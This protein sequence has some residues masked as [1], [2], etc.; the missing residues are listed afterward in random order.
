MGQGA[1]TPEH[2]RSLGSHTVPH[3]FPSQ[4]ALP[5]ATCGHGV[6]LLPHVSSEE[7]GTQTPLHACM[8]VS[9]IGWQ[10]PAEHSSL[11]WQA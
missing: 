9:Q 3:V 2:R 10:V 4:V 8:P 6:Q 5:L 7:S 11:L 1:Q